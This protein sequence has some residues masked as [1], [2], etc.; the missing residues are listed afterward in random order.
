MITP[1]IRQDL[2]IFS[3]NAMEDGSP[4]WMLYDGLTNKYFTLGLNAFRM[5][6]H[7]IA[8]VESKLFIEE[9]EKKGISIQEDQLNDFISFLKLN[10]LIIHQNSED[11]KILIHKY[12]S[13]QKH[14]ILKLIHNYLFFRIPLIKPDNFLDKTLSMAKFLGTN[15]FRKLIYIIG[16]IGFY[17]VIQNWSEFKSTFLYFFN[18]NGLLFYAI[19]LVAVK[20][21]HELGHAYTAKNFGCNVNSMGIAFLVFFPFLYTDNTNVWR[22][23]DHKKRLT[24]NFAGISTEIHLA[25]IATFFWSISEPGLFKSVAFFVATTSW[26]SSL[27][28]NISP[29]MRFDG[30]YIFADYLKLENLQPR[31]FA[32][33]KWKLREIL[34]GLNK[35]APETMQT[36][37]RNLLILYAWSTWIYRF[38]LFIGIALLVYFYA[39]K[40]LGI[41][42]FAVEIIWF[43]GIPIGKEV[44]AWWKLK[45][46]FILSF[47]LL[48]TIFVLAFLI[49]TFFYPWKNYQK[50]PAIFQADQSTSIY[51]PIDSQIKDIYINEG[52][53]VEIN[54]L[55]ISLR[56]PELELFISQT[57]EE[58]DLISIKIDNSLDD[59]LSRSQ[60]LVL[61]SEKQKYKTQLNNL[62]KVRS[63]LEIVSPFD[64]EII[65]SLHLK[66]NQWVNKDDPLFSLVNKNS[67]NIIAFISERD[68]GQVIRNKDVKFTSLLNNELNLMAQISSISQSPVNNFDLYPMVTSIFDG[69]IAARQK[70]SGGIQSEEAFYVMKMS[71]ISDDKF[72]DQK[73]LGNAQIVVKPTSLSE[74]L[75][76]TVY[77][78]LIRELNF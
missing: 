19:S 58:L 72:S 31:A 55:M 46:D 23:R 53:L 22:L 52:Q 54:Q 18:W 3:G 9:I 69:P 34:F 44:L 37:R 43:I 24:I 2:Q 36:H 56:S 30:Y 74:R 8:G 16:L 10:D 4:S 45:S 62:L 68:I 41:I 5:L 66:K 26:I 28:I 21:V 40:L 6:K 78:V 38:F 12:K 57:K 48:R 1:N 20:A 63:S 33:A 50:I 75:Y 67:H 49:F 25:I 13:Q 61:K 59:D 65:S 15:F 32:L 71:L 60:L 73:T 42:L 64:G 29:F 76:K 70:P 77:A 47:K 39:F 27:L 51:A 7:W 14:W 35:N 17:L 11:V